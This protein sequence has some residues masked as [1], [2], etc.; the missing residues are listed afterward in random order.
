MKSPVRYDSHSLTNLGFSVRLNP[1][2]SL[3]I[4]SL[5]IGWSTFQVHPLGQDQLAKNEMPTPQ[6][7]T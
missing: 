3:S 2:E 4:E 5:S 6:M 1:L 7:V